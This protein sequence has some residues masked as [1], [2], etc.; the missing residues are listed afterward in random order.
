L[1]FGAGFSAIV[2]LAGKVKT[3]VITREVTR[4]VMTPRLSD[5]I[6]AI[7]RI[8]M[9]AE[10]ELGKKILVIL[11]DLDKVNLEKGE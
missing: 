7:N 6:D 2:N 1:E 8:L 5:L 10:K 9:D 3:Q 4:D 11:D